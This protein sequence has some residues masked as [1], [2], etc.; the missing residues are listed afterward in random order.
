M[1]EFN[2]CATREASRDVSRQASPWK[3]GGRAPDAGGSG[4]GAQTQGKTC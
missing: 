2:A 4:G 3:V 1:S